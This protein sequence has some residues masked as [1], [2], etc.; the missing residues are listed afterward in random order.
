MDDGG[1]ADEQEKSAEQQDQRQAHPLGGGL[2]GGLGV[3]ELAVAD[4]GGLGGE[5]GPDLG[6]FDTGQGDGGGQFAQLADAEFAAELAEGFPGRAAGQ[7]GGFQRGP[8]LG[9]RPAAAAS[10]SSVPFTRLPNRCE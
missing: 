5:A 7:P 10:T 3:G 4:G 1:E 6:A 2:G 8:D 9:E